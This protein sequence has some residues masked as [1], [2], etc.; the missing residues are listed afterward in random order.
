MPDTL[1]AWNRHQ[2][3]KKWTFDNHLAKTGRPRKT[4]DTEALMWKQFLQSHLEMAWATDFFTEEVWTLSG[5][6]T[7]Y[8]LFSIHLGTRRAQFTG[9]TPQP[10]ARWMQQQAGNFSLLVAENAR[11]PSYLVHDR[12]GAFFPLD[13]VVR[14]AGS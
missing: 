8:T 2:K 3:Q 13:Q 5:L 10:E 12:D 6:V 1:L 9:C 4:R 14:P 11:Q 7:Y